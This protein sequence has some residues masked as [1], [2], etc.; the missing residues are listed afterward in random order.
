MFQGKIEQ[1]KSFLEIYIEL[2]VYRN[3]NPAAYRILFGLH[4]RTV[5]ES[6]VISRN[7]QRVIVHPQ[8]SSRNFVN[9]IALMQ[10]SVRI[11]FF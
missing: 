4:D 11:I 10:L 8:Y 5:Q 2:I 6:W 3:T 7:V 9:D 1:K